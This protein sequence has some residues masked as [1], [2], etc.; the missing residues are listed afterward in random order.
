MAGV[1]LSAGYS[2][3]SG[4]IAAGTSTI[5]LRQQGSAVAAL[6][7]PG[8]ALS[9]TTTIEIAG[10]YYASD[11]PAISLEASI[12]SF[13][14]IAYWKLD[15]VSGT[16]ATD[17]SGN[18]RHGAYANSPTLGGTF[19]PFVAPTFAAATTQHVNIY[20]ASLAGAYNDATGTML[21]FVR[22]SGANPAL[23]NAIR[24][25]TTTNNYTARLARNDASSLAR[26]DDSSGTTQRIGNATTTDSWGMLAMTWDSGANVIELFVNGVSQ[27]TEVPAAAWA[28]TLATAGCVISGQATTGTVLRWQGQIAHVALFSTVLSAANIAAIYAASGL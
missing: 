20:S 14:P 23:R 2:M 22:A 27:G 12:L 10:M 16:V 19:G 24:L 21:L 13:G 11:V 3:L 1:T 6:T 18:A 7:L 15:E 9:A 17:A 28:D 25:A 4:E 5:K 8:T 26:R